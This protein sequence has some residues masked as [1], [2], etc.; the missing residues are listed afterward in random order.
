MLGQL[1]VALDQ[2]VSLS[3]KADWVVMA[4]WLLQLR[5]R[6]LLPTPAEA[7]RQEDDADQP[8]EPQAASSSLQALA[9]W[10]MRRPQLGRDV[11]ARG[12]PEFTGVAA[13]PMFEVDMV[14]FLWAT[15]A[16]RQNF[17]ISNKIQQ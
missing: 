13:T 10:L 5:S 15:L 1:S 9:A 4:A 16:T 6:L 3:R 7:E 17:R 11:F 12:Q 8:C 2:A 14:E